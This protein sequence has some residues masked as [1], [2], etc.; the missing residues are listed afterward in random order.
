MT[1]EDQQKRGSEDSKEQ[2]K[3]LALKGIHKKMIHPKGNNV[4]GEADPQAAE[5]RSAAWG[6]G[7]FVA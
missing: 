7:Y 3:K 5:K 4:N 1:K 6:S 2:K